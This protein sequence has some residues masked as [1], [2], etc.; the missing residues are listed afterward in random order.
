MI[1]LKTL[2][3]ATAQEVFDQVAKHLLTQNKACYG[4]LTVGICAYRNDEGLKCAAGCLIAD[5]EYKANWEQLG[6]I[7][8]VNDGVVPAEHST[9]IRELQIIHDESNPDR[10]RDLLAELAADYKLNTEA[11]NLGELV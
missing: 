9:L 3:K 1:T 5:D 4:H 8:L 10:W 6:W 7:S 2:P 11:L